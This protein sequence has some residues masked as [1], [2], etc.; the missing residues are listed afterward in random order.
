MERSVI[1]IPGFKVAEFQGFKVKNSAFGPSR[2][3]LA[4]TTLNM[5]AAM[6]NI[7]QRQTLQ[8]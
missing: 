5:A 7:T 1:N 8:P 6:A 4:C 3:N 2:C